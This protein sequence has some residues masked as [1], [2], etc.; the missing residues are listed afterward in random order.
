MA[1]KWRWRWV[2]GLQIS[3]A[4]LRE[5]HPYPSNFTAKKQHVLVEV[6]SSIFGQKIGRNHPFFTQAKG[7]NGLPFGFVCGHIAFDLVAAGPNR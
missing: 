1:K 6:A 4:T 5:N 2:Y 7:R 3:N